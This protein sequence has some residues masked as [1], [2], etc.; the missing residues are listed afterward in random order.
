RIIDTIET[1]EQ[2]W[3]VLG[4][5]T[6][7]EVSN[8]ELQV[9]VS[10]GCS[11]FDFLASRR[12]FQSVINQVCEDLMDCIFVR[13]D[14]DIRRCGDLDREAPAS[15]NFAERCLRVPQQF[16]S[17]NRGLLQPLLARLDPR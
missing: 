8:I 12:I 4:G 7:T 11:D 3:Q 5:D 13:E 16:V 15:G 6:G 2:S 9:T 10:F 17:S 1:F 14:L